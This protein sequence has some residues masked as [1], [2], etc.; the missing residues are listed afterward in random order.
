MSSQGKTI[1]AFVLSLLSGI[2]ILVGSLGLGLVT[3]LVGGT[4]AILWK[5][6]ETKLS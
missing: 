1:V 3:G 2:L 6:E 4:M 5:P